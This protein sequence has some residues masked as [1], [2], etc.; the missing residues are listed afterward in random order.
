M[1]GEQDIRHGSQGV[2]LPVRHG[3]ALEIAVVDGRLVFQHIEGRGPHPSA[4]EGFNESFRIH[5][6]ATGHIDENHARLHGSQGIPVHQMESV[7][8]RRRVEGDD[9]TL[10]EK[11]LTGHV[12]RQS[13]YF[14]ILPHVVREHAA[15]EGLQEMHHPGADA[16]R[17]HNAH[18][19]AAELAPAHAPETEIPGVKA[20]HDELHVSQAHE[21]GHDRVLRHGVRRVAHVGNGDAEPCGG[22]EVDVVK[23]HGARG[24]SPDTPRGPGLKQRR[25]DGLG[26]NAEPVH[27]LHGVGVPGRRRVIAQD[28]V[29][30]KPGSRLLKMLPLIRTHVESQKFHP[31]PPR[32]AGKKEEGPCLLPLRSRLLYTFFR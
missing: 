26:D 13:L 10:P 27:P 29:R 31:C 30:A 19:A 18:G 23:T 2:H 22:S 28:N 16:A 1:R 15:A 8:N 14:G 3:P 24:H 20:A 6:S 12:F 25:A 32:A 7:R 17:S 4:F 21:H 11:L 9:V 5:H